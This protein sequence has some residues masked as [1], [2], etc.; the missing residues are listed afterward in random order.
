MNEG[1]QSSHA[2]TVDVE[3][4]IQ[5][6]YDADSP[7][8]DCFIRN[9]HCI[10]ELLD[11]HATKAT[12]F[13]LGLAAEKCPQLVRDIHRA[14]HEVQS[15]GWGHRLL[16][17]LTREQ[18]TEDVSRSKRFL[19]DLIGREVVGYRAPAFGV[20]RSTLWALDALIEAGYY[21]DSS[22]FPVQMP[23]YGIRGVPRIPFRVIA[24]NGGS[25]LEMPVA[26]CRTVFGRRPVAGGG[27]FR[28]FPY[29]A[30]RRTAQQ[31]EHL[32]QPAVFYVHPYEFAPDEWRRVSVRIP[33]RLRLHQSVGRRGVKIKVGRLLTDF[34]FSPLR[35][36]IPSLDRVPIV[37]FSTRKETVAK[38]EPARFSP[39]YGFVSGG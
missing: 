35:S 6:V 24:P 17:T 12:F 28:L 1:L 22:I 7:L 5:S 8:T 37:N 20:T 19:E 32:G 33:L 25:L 21:Y 29:P 18:F 27:Y 16:A 11:A 3:D 31:F 2:L 34:S 14:G 9:T 13:V 15:H 23:R 39:L 30:I 10:L 38:T 36:I 4:W 26:S